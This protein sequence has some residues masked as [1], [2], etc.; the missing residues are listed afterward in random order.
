MLKRTDILSPAP[1]LCYSFPSL[2]ILPRVA[3]IRAIT[4]IQINTFTINEISQYVA[5]YHDITGNK[6]LK[7]AQ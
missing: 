4:K 2:V 6:N 1:H 3:A 5:L 7:S